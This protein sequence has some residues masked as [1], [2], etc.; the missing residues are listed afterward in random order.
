[1]PSDSQVI[2]PIDT[3]T[4][5]RRGGTY[6]SRMFPYSIGPRRL[7]DT[8]VEVA[9]GGSWE[10]QD[11][12][13]DL[14]FKAAPGQMFFVPA[15]RNHLLRMIEG[16]PMRSR[17][18]LI[19]LEDEVGRDLFQRLPH[20]IALPTKPSTRAARLLK[21]LERPYGIGL[22]ECLAF[23]RLGLELVSLIL[24]HCSVPLA[25]LP[26]AALRMEQV[27]RFIRDHLH[28][29]LS[30][31]DLARQA[32]LSP[33][34]FHYVFL[35]ATGQ[36]PMKYLMSQ[37]MHRARQLLLSTTLSSKEVGQQCGFNSSAHFSR[38]FTALTGISP[39]SY[40]AQIREPH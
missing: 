33:T 32:H 6:G 4:F 15:E 17:W 12:D 1:M 24:E 21:E 34:R 2:R 18:A 22:S 26:K 31:R 3:L 7:A 10:V 5:R 36:S 11:L 8:L 25:A 38:L 35:E 9:T 14:T 29:P 30:R 39:L 28:E 20:A 19:A 16:R 13:A 37:R 27:L 23:Q 40:R